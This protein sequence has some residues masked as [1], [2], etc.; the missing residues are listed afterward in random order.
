[1]KRSKK[2]DEQ[3]ETSKKRDMWKRPKYE[4]EMR[5]KKIR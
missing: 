5:K 4:E 2:M 3:K 1:M